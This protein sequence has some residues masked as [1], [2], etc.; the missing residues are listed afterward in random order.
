MTQILIILLY[1]I[2]SNTKGQTA[3]KTEGTAGVIPIKSV[4]PTYPVTISDSKGDIVAKSKG[5][6]P[7]SKGKGSKEIKPES[8][9]TN[10]L[11]GTNNDTNPPT[12]TNNGTNSW[13]VI[14]TG[15]NSNLGNS[16]ISSYS[17]WNMA[18][19]VTQPVFFCRHVKKSNPDKDRLEEFSVS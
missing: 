12:G 9:C 1:L 16:P 13:V 2:L 17:P 11:A 7:K 6:I 5:V 8:K 14:L 18:A 10:P 15:D 3:G 19:A 4:N